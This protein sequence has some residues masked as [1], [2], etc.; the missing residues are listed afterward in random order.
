[1]TSNPI[2]YLAGRAWAFAGTHRWL[3]LVY[4]ALFACAQAISLA[5]P[6]VIGQML[7]A[8]QQ[9]SGTGGLLRDV[10]KGAGLYL[11]LQLAFWLFHGP[12]RVLER[13]VA[14]RIRVQF[15][16]T[17]FRIATELPLQWHRDN[18]SGDSIDRMN[19]AATALFEFSQTSFMLIYMFL[20]LGGA[21][22]I[23]LWFSPAAGVATLVTTAATFGLVFAFDKVLY[24]HYR[25]INAFE[26]R[27]AS[28]VH[29][30]VTNMA[31]V[32]TLRL[33]SR[34]L[35]ETVRRIEGSFATFRANVT[36]NEVKWFLTNMLIG[37]MIAVVLAWYAHSTLAGGQALLGGTLFALF[38]YLRRIGDSFFEF[39][40]LYGMTV[41][42][43]ADVRGA[44]PLEEAH[45]QVAANVHAAPLPEGW[46]ALGI[47]GLSFTYQ[48]EKLR[49]HHLEDVSIELRKGKSIALVGASGSGKS[50]LLTLLRGLHPVDRAAMSC[51]GAPVEGGLKPLAA[52]TT[53]LPQNPEIFA[54]TI[55]FNITFGVEADDQE[56]LSAIRLARFDGVLERLPRGLDT[57]VSEKGVN[58]SGG[59][60][61][62]L[63][64]ARGIFFSRESD[65]VLLDEPTSSVDAHSEKLI[66]LNLLE[67]YR[68]RALVSSVHKLHL[69][70]LFDRIYV[71]SDGRVI[72]QGDFYTLLDSGGALT[73]LWESYQAAERA[74]DGPRDTAPSE[75][76]SAP[77]N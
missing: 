32:L 75:L 29:D 67:L 6:F 3:M 77:V 73:A 52:C 24:G 11:F 36:L 44:E 65:V 37:L 68:D 63:A 33:E 16:S 34:V 2:L 38:E 41:R 12:A 66:Y 21:L 23:L 42:Q 39:A 7:N 18:H 27:V 4:L 58:L 47:R 51:D 60:R 17:L 5:E 15:R 59:E 48:D 31:T 8:I 74:P 54:D 46:S 61:Q 62:R 64:L 40:N 22:A 19:R 49:A 55:R 14:F 30:Y 76:A 25:S 53:L 57:D 35:R 71:L 50:T 13:F 26:R 1:M 72:E 9:A 56:V 45:R 43:S 70:P 69:L 20:R 28:A 10:A